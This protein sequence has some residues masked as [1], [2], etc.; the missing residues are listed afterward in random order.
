MATTRISAYDEVVDFLTSE[1]TPEQIIAFR[2]SEA[3][4]ERL[5]DYRLKPIGLQNH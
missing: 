4:Q 2:P 5:N 3:V 1:P